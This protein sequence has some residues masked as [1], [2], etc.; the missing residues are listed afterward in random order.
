MELD[1]GAGMAGGG[2]GGGGGGGKAT[3]VRNRGS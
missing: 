3:G 1:S 2:G